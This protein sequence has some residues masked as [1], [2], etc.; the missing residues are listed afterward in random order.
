MPEVARNSLSA[1]P[2]FANNRIL[3]GFCDAVR[4]FVKENFEGL[5]TLVAR[6]R[7]GDGHAQR[8]E[9]GVRASPI[10]E[11]RHVHTNLLLGPLG[12]ID[13]RKPLGNS[14]TLLFHERGD[15]RDPAA[16]DAVLIRP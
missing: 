3:H 5:V 15:A 13:V 12:L 8:V 6:I 14:N 9:G 4:G 16:V 1:L 10:R 7:T 11:T 2:A